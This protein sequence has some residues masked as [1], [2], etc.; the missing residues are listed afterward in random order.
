MMP[1][2]THTV[3]H[4]ILV[5]HSDSGSNLRSPRTSQSAPSCDTIIPVV[6]LGGWQNVLQKSRPAD[7]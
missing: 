4:A 5:G 3:A 1:V 2:G 6:T 7:I